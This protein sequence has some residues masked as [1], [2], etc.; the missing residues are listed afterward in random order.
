AARIAYQ[1]LLRAPRLSIL[2]SAL[3]LSLALQYGVEGIYGPG[4]E[5]YPSVLRGQALSVGGVA[6]T[7][8]Q[9][10]AVAA[11]VVLMMTLD[12]FVRRTVLGTAM[13]ALAMDQDAARLMGIDVERVILLT[14]FIG[15]ALAAAAGFMS[16]LY[17][18]QISFLMGFILGLRA[19]TAAV[20][21]GIGNIPG[22]MVGG[23]LIGLLESYASG[24][25]SGTW[26][27]VAV[28]GVLI[29]VLV[30]RPSGIFGERA[31]ERV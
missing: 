22:A 11:A 20:L 10:V 14:F 8:S 12:H 2:I 15:T 29:A 5:S 31:V 7:I 6:V 3:G 16:G 25:G 26:K 17:Y 19:F 30:V 9:L 4:F 1:P 21:G 23:F 28:F 24:Y 27:D 13:R 18:G